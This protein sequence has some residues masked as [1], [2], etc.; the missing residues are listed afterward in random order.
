MNVCALSRL[1]SSSP[2]S[3]LTNSSRNTRHAARLEADDRNS[4]TDGFPQRL[5]DLRSS[6]FAVSSMP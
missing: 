1:A 4:G 5:E 6:A 3:R 2:Y